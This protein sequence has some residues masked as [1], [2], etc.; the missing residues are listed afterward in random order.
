MSSLPLTNR[1]A[2]GVSGEPFGKYLLLDRIGHGGMAEVFR[3]V[4][5]GPEGFQR[6]LVIKRILPDLSQDPTFVRMFIDEA[7]VSGLL[8]HPNLVQIYEFG[9][10]NESFFIVMEHVHGRTLTAVHAKL[11]KLGRLAPVAATVEIGRQICVGLHHAHSLR[12]VGGQP[13]G[14]VHRD[15]SPSNVMLAFHGGVTILDFGIARMAEGL[16]E[17]Q[18]QAGGIKGKISY[19]SPEQIR[20]ET[21]DQR[22]D[23]F[24]VGVVLHEMLTGRRLFRGSSNFNAAR[25][26]VEMPIPLPSERNPTVPP[27]L[28]RLVMRALASAIHP[29]TRRSSCW[30][31]S[32]SHPSG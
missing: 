30:C 9:K 22:S 7:R 8:S 21:V 20:N 29:T 3:A 11:A 23:I 6:A 31:C 26:V 19:M 24:A 18:T 16:R 32:E 1:S 12:S 25:K 15:I 4:V 17:T 14:I 5:R 27:A 2:R 10:V 13:L 28:D